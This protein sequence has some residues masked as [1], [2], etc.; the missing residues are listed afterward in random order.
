[1]QNQS[2]RF[3]SQPEPRSTD[4]DGA[5]V[6]TKADS[7]DSNPPI[8]PEA[9]LVEFPQ[10]PSS[11]SGMGLVDADATLVDL[12]VTMAEGTWKAPSTGPKPLRQQ[13][14]VSSLETGDVMAGRYEI[15]Q[16][17]GEGG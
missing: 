1:M 7:S 8:D 14:S 16:L 3:D 13:T 15:L 2:R 10:K 4:R 9:T 11:S 6:P 5:S 12:D 17:L